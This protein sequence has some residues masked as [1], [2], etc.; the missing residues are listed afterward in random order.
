MTGQLNF[1]LRG[2][3]TTGTE[4]RGP[5]QVAASDAEKRSA[6]VRAA[7][8]VGRR[9]RTPQEEWWVKELIG[10][11]RRM[12]RKPGTPDAPADPGMRP[13]GIRERALQSV[14]RS[15]G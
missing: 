12:W 3:A 15:N 2:R 11:I 1:D 6:P 8:R 10:S 4:L 9:K 7:R 5:D 14:A 13:G